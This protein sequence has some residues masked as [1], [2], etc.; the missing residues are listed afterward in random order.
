MYCFWLFLVYTAVHNPR[1]R[2]THPLEDCPTP[3]WVS[4]SRWLLL[5]LT[6]R[7]C[8]PADPLSF[9]LPC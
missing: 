1:W 6:A 4:H 5:D 7:R 8:A 9:M 2:A 3:L